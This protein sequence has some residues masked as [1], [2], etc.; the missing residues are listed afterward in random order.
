LKILFFTPSCNHSHKN[1]S[2]RAILT[3]DKSVLVKDSSHKSKSSL[4]T[5][6]ASFSSYQAINFDK[7][8]VSSTVLVKAQA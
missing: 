3:Q 2:G 7:I 8:T 5:L 4:F 1:S 6:V